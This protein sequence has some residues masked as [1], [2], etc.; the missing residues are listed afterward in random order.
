MKQLLGLLLVLPLAQVA[1]GQ[2]P[3][4][5]SSEQQKVYERLLVQ[6]QQQQAEGLQLATD[7]PYVFLGRPLTSESYQDK[8]GRYYESTVY[9]VVAVLRGEPGI[10]PGTVTLNKQSVYHEGQ[11]LIPP[12]P[13]YEKVL[14]TQ[15]L[16]MTEWGIYFC[17]PS[18]V[19]GNPNPYLTSNRA[20]LALYAPYSH[21]QPVTAN[22]MFLDGCR[23]VTY[24]DGLGY[25]FNSEKEMNDFLQR[26]PNLQPLA[27]PV[28]EY[29][30][31]RFVDE[32][33]GWKAYR[34]AHPAL[35]VAT[36]QAE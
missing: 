8:T 2:T 10:K 33:P 1:Q 20:P 18:T 17:S 16:E 34:K 22:A 32:R 13:G 3:A 24:I 4:P 31:L 14:Q 30:S 29:P 27:K 21:L 6:Q 28:R 19:V 25:S 9:Q 26:V 23:E 12:K 5:L 36:E 11:R 15:F 7:A 35:P